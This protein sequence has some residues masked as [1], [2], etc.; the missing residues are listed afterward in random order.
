MGDDYILKLMARPAPATRWKA[1]DTSFRASGTPWL[2]AVVVLAGCNDPDG[3]GSSGSRAAL[4]S[5]VP[6]LALERALP[7]EGRPG[8]EPSG[9]S[10]VNGRLYTVSDG[11]DPTIYA[12]DIDGHRAVAKPALVVSS[13]TPGVALDFEGIAAD[14]D[15]AF[16]LSSE[17]QARVLRVTKDGHS[18]WVTPTLTSVGQ[19]L[20]LLQ[21]HNAG[22]EGVARLADGTLLLA[23][24][25]DAPGLIQVPP[26]AGGRVQAGLANPG[27]TK[28]EIRALTVPDCG[29]LH[30]ARRHADL[31]DLTTSGTQVFALARNEQRVV[32]LEQ[33]GGSWEAVEAW[34]FKATENDP[35]YAYLD[36]RFPLAEGLVVTEDHVYVVLDNNQTNGRQADPKDTRPTLFVFKRP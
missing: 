21:A 7:I 29:C 16:L 4:C 25:R 28:P 14:G 36:Q 13:P 27:V 31:S 11:D 15:G 8:L 23:A 34:S 32:R 2:C 30:T 22:L 20:G 26:A 9:L 1:T 17:A 5:S 18:A 19:T 24:E 12:L 33:K 6:E 3:K 10:R 35:R